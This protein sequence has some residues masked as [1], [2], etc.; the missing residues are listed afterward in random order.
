MKECQACSNHSPDNAEI[1]DNCGYNFE[2]AEIVDKEKL[3]GYVSKLK[4]EKQWQGEVNL[5]KNVNSIQIKKYGH[6]STSGLGG[7][8][9]RKTAELFG[10]RNSQTSTHVRIA[11]AFDEYPELLQYRNVFQASRF[12]DRIRAKGVSKCPMPIF[13]EKD[14]QKNLYNNWGETELSRD[15]DLQKGDFL[16]EGRY[17]TEIGE[18][19]LLA[20]HRNQERWLV[21]ELKRDQSSDETVGQ[22]LSYMGWVKINL[23]GNKDGRVDGLII[24]SSFN[25]RMRFAL[26]C[27]PNIDLRV[28][29]FEDGK[30]RLKKPQE[31]DL[32]SLEEMF[33]KMTPE[34]K[35]AQIKRLQELCDQK[36]KG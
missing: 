20:K 4:R 34:Q 2:K 7:W 23:A 22:I 36:D 29:R 18:I 19:D 15:W 11:E 6:S 21:I 30:L 13:E 9:E 28:H 24:A 10:E 1:C 3:L 17:A 26:E 31:A 25:K 5:K 35:D 8:S 12:L 32:E 33:I 14:L 27:V 16:K